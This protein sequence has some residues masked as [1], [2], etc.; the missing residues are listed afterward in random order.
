MG[1]EDLE[2]IY[3]LGQR[4][5]AVTFPLVERIGI[6]DIHDK[7]FFLA[8]IMNLGLRSVSTHV[9]NMRQVSRLCCL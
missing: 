2:A 9:D 7:I 1:H 8:L 5:R 4:D 6:V 3:D